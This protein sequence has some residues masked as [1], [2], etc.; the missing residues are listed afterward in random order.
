MINDAGILPDKRGEI[1]EWDEECEEGENAVMEG[2]GRSVRLRK[3]TKKGEP[4]RG[5]AL[6]PFPFHYVEVRV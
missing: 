3:R 6:S 5:G 2:C 1:G 4:R